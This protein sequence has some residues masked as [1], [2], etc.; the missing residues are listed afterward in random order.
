MP[1]VF[2][3]VTLE[4]QFGGR[5]VHRNPV[6]WKT[7][8]VHSKKMFFFQGP[9]SDSMF[10]NL[11]LSSRFP[12]DGKLKRLENVF[13]QRGHVSLKT[14]I[15]QL[16]MLVSLSEHEFSCWHLFCCLGKETYAASILACVSG[17][18]W[19]KGFLGSRCRLLG[20]PPLETPKHLSVTLPFLKML[21][22]EDWGSVIWGWN[23]QLHLLYSKVT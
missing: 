16:A 12:F 7:K 14:S 18:Q 6:T 23:N 13:F 17:K 2:N 3:G 15:F 21:S 11:S 22:R 5:G 1:L 4:L 20:R 9:F 10:K 8:T 19:A